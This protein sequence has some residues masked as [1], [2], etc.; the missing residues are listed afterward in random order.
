M[1]MHAPWSKSFLVEDPESGLASPTGA[2]RLS[3]IDLKEFQRDELVGQ[4]LF[5]EYS[6]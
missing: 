3:Q 6:V 5:S 2:I 1:V 4:A